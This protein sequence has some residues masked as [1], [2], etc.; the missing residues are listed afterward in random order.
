MAKDLAIVLNNGS[1]NSAV[2][3]ALAAQKYRVVMLHAEIA[4]PPSSRIRVAFERQVEHFKPY[5]DHLLPMPY[6]AM[7][8]PLGRPFSTLSDPRQAAAN[9]GPQLQEL[10][11]LVAAAARIAAHYEA[12]AI[13]L[14]LRIGGQPDE[15]AQATEYVQ[16]WN[17]LIQMPCRR[18]DLEVVAPLL[19]LEPWQAVDLGFQVSAPLQHAWSCQE[20]SG[21]PCWTCKSCRAR[22]AAFQQAGKPDPARE[23][24]EKR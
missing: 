8:Q 21:Q 18:E 10:L 9:L 11:P 16:V 17:E 3:T 22:E 2:A 13:Y 14:G 4:A 24:Q 19:E 7:V 6:L 15:L 20:E 23:S 12:A 1:L 5:R